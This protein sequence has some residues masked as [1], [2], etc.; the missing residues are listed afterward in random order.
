MKEILIGLLVVLCTIVFATET[1][2]AKAKAVDKPKTFFLVPHQ[3]DELLTYG[4][5][6][7]S[8]LWNG[9]DVHLVLMTDGSKSVARKVISK[10]LG[11]EM[12]EQE[13]RIA[14]TKEFKRSAQILGVPEGNIHYENY[15]DGQLTAEDVKYVVTKLNKKYPGSKFKAIS[16]L[17]PH[18]DHAATGEG[19]QQLY[20][21]GVVDDVRFYLSSYNFGTVRTRGTI[22][23]KYQERFQPLIEGAALAYNRWQPEL[24]W[25]AAGHTSVP[26]LYPPL[27]EK[28]Y[29]RYH[30][31]GYGR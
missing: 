29:S 2:D 17:D 23:D 13:F 16:Y 12:S 25:Y 30:L 18:T 31:P 9:D 19:L 20:D 21:E 5:G 3:D 7:L 24:G 10:K 27:I 14:R 8:H 6:I 15:V 28:P 11:R 22:E 4:V 26:K 1:V